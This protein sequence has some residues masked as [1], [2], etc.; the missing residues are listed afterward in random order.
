MHRSAPSH[1]RLRTAPARRRFGAARAGHHLA[2]SNRPDRGRARPICR[3]CLARHCDRRVGETDTGH[4]P[5]RD[6][7]FRSGELRWRHGLHGGRRNFEHS[8]AHCPH[9]NRWSMGQRRHL[10]WRRR[11]RCL[12]PLV[13]GQLQQLSELHCRRGGRR[14]RGVNPEVLHRDERRVGTRRWVLVPRP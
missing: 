6:R 2:V 3:P 8:V 13:L 14:I 7:W 10:W 11:R 9:R 4:G 5:A 1:R 12:G